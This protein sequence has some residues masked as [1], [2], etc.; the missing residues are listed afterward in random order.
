MVEE[1]KF[2]AHVYIETGKEKGSHE[3][4][5]DGV[6]L[7]NDQRASAERR[8]VKKLDHRL[9][10]TIVVIY[11]MNY[12]DVRQ[13]HWV[14]WFVCLWISIQRSAVTSARLSGLEQDL[15]L[16]GECQDIYKEYT[17]V[18]PS[19]GSNTVLCCTGDLICSILSSSDSLKYGNT[20]II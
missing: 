14:Q 6:L 2:S 10:P 13:P 4:D 12:I 1:K 11:I 18:Y 19:F 7:E 17:Y 3:T 20:I 15:H 5:N 8:L 16:T 9:L